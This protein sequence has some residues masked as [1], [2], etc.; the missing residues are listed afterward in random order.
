MDAFFEMLLELILEPIMEVYVFAMSKIFKKINAV[1][2]RYIVVVEALILLGMFVVG[3]VMLLIT[4][5]ES[6]AGKII[7]IIS[8]TVSF[9]QVLLG[10]ILKKK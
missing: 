7:F 8:I 1:T 2:A 3:G 6:I 10:I 5:G 9:V 4:N